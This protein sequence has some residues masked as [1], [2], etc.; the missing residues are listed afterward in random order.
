[1]FTDHSPPVFRRKLGIFGVMAG[2][3]ALLVA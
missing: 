1:M 3:A 2:I